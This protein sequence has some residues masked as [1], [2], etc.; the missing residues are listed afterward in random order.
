MGKENAVYA[1]NG[2]YAE[3]KKKE[4]LSYATTWVNFKDSVLR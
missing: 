4:I 2:C 3:L 1:H